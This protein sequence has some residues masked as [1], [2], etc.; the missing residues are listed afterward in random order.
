VTDEWLYRFRRRA[1][2]R[3]IPKGAP[4]DVSRAAEE[5]FAEAHPGVDDGRERLVELVEM[6]LADEGQTIVTRSEGGAWAL[7]SRQ[8]FG[9]SVLLSPDGRVVIGYATRNVR[10]YVKPAPVS[11]EVADRRQRF[12][13]REAKA[14][15]EALVRRV[16]GWAREVFEGRLDEAVARDKAKRAGEVERFEQRL[17]NLR[18]EA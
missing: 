11:V 4:P 13:Q 1:H 2:L 18:A 7:L 16:N 3:D 6:L 14:A 12:Q 17:A 8:P 15:R 5:S 9:Y 10:P